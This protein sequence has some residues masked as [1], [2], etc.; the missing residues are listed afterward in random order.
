[1]TYGTSIIDRLDNGFYLKKILPIKLYKF[2]NGFLFK[3]MNLLNLYIGCIMVFY[4]KNS[5]K[6]FFYKF[7]NGFYLKKLT[8]E[9]SLIG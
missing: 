1:M 3:Y 6:Y 7:I 8:Y 9:T 4:L 2:Y 5:L